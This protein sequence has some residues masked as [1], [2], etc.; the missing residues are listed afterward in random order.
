MASRKTVVVLG[1]GDLAIR[2]AGWFHASPDHA[3]VAV[4]PVVPEPTWTG[5]LG[6]WAQAHGV[7]TVA[8][9]HYRD[10][11]PI[12]GGTID[13]GLS[14]FYDRIVRPAFIGRFARLLN[15]HNAPL[16]RY[17][18][19]SP[20]NWALK[21]GER[22][23]GVT[24]HEMTPEVDAGPIVAQV[25]F[26][27]WPDRDE[28]MDVYRRALAFGWL[29]FEE[30]AASLDELPAAPQDEAQATYYATADNERLGERR[31]FTRAEHRPRA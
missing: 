19:V 17:R 4:V 29:L 27:I 22:E 14:V 31:F 24:I 21:N 13:L 25:R 1:K 23:H 6:D 11:P 8:S 12:A 20:I 9:G 5:S 10:L 26:S 18:G 2:V 16:P 3:L 15:L 7:P 28:V 30:T